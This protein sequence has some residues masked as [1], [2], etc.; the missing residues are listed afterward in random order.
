MKTLC[1]IFLALLLPEGLLTEKCGES[2]ASRIVGGTVANTRQFPY[3]T[4]L[5]RKK[6][7]NRTLSLACGGSLIRSN[8]VLTA[9]HCYDKSE[10]NWM[11]EYVAVFDIRD[12]CK[13][14]YDGFSDITY[15]DMHPLWNTNTKNCDLAIATLQ[16]NVKYDTICLSP[17]GYNKYPTSAYVVGLGLTE[18]EG[19]T[20]NV[21]NL[22]QINIQ[23]F[24]RETC[25]GTV[26]AG[27]LQRR[28]GILCAGVLSGQFDSCQGDS[29]G[30]LIRVERGVHYLQGV[31][32]TGAG[33]GRANS[34][35][36]YA[37]V[38]AHRIWID[39]VLKKTPQTNPA[40]GY[41]Y[42]PRTTVRPSRGRTP[43]SA[44]RTSPSR[45]RV[46]QSGN[47]G[48][49]SSSDSWPQISSSRTFSNYTSYSN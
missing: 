8:K 2:V 6:Y 7:F 33:C 11:D 44:R 46:P 5:I 45:S 27:I 14:Q 43:S 12:R 3:Y 13:R 42:G 16:E 22:L 28:T 20:E 17:K 18:E 37:D 40:P 1:A 25:M 48:F 35:G 34:P 10:P 47:L 29:G 30:P 23:I 24:T 21:C 19:T 15:V 31:V 39:R 9:A 41:Q 4:G 36:I 32:S 49:S 38:T 26:M